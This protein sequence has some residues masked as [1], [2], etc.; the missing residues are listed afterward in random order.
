[1][2]RQPA[3][4]IKRRY[5]TVIVPAGTSGV[6]ALRR[7]CPLNSKASPAVKEKR[8]PRRGLIVDFLS[9]SGLTR[10]EWRPPAGAFGGAGEGP[11][12]AVGGLMI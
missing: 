6:T 5:Q 8:K 9:M 3:R 10:F 12:P 2:V 4:R 1:M 11:T 7:L